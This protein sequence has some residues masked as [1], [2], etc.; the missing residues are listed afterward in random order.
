MK[1]RLL[2]LLATGLCTTAFLR[3]ESYSFKEPFD[4]SAP[5]NSTGEISLENVNGSVEIR[6][7]DKNEI[8]IEGEKNAKTEEEL[9]LIDLTIDTAPDRVG[10]KVRL[11]KRSGGWFWGSN[12]R[13]AVRFTLTVPA[14]ATLRKINTVNSR[15]VIDGVRG[16][17]NASTVN[18]SIE[19]TR[20]GADAR[21]QTVNGGLTVSFDALVP[22][23]RISLETVNGGITV[24]LPKNAGVSVDASVVNGGVSCDFPIT[25][26][27][28]GVHRHSLHGAIGGG[29]ASLHASSVNGGIH[30]REL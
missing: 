7:W 25:L 24:K 5:F 6:T 21:L 28:G 1:L 9:K 13:A 3:A 22:T 26:S 30:L 2:A 27:G 11:P 23:Q 8:R 16:E 12:I 15:V 10:I 29:G 19:A 20:L 18:G 4:R 17:V 14:T